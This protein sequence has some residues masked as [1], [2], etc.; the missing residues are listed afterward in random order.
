M[1][2]SEETKQGMNIE[3][4]GS[5]L[6]RMIVLGSHDLNLQIT[7]TPKYNHLVPVMGQLLSHDPNS[8]L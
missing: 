6:H 1:D 4:Q 3:H 7:I 8:H 5:G 2:T